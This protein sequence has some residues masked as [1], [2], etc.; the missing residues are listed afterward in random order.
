MNLDANF[1][2]KT[3][4]NYLKRTNGHRI[5]RIFDDFIFNEHVCMVLEL[6]G[7]VY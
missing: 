5:I 7:V 3:E 1:E 4:I 2:G 6:M